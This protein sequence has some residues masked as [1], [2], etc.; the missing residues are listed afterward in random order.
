MSAA[1]AP[2]SLETRM[3]GRGV[4][5]LA[6]KAIENAIKPAH[7]REF[8]DRLFSMPDLAAVTLGN[9]KARLRFKAGAGRAP[10]LLRG[11]AKVMRAGKREQFT[12]ADLELIAVVS[13][14]RPIRIWRTGDRLT[15]LRVKALAPER[16]RFYHPEFRDA[17][18]RAAIIRELTGIA[19]VKSPDGSGWNGG[20][21]E[22]GFHV[23]RMTSG[24]L[25]AIIEEALLATIASA[26]RNSTFEFR[27]RLVDTNLA[28]A[29]VSDFLFPPAR[30]LSIATLW[31]L[32]LRHVRPSM[33]A[34]RNWKVNLHV[35]YS[36]IALL[37]LLSLSF[38][39]SAVMYWMFEFWPRRVKSLR[40]A[41]TARFLA[42]LKRCPRSVWVDRDGTEMEVELG[43]L[44]IG[45]TV[46][47]R[48]GDVAPGDG[49]LISG[50]VLVAESW[51]AGVHRRDVGDVIHCSGQIARGEGR[52]RLDTL[53]AGAVTST[54]ADWHA[55]AMRAPV[56]D[57]KVKRMATAAVL[58][59]LALAALA[60]IRG[61]VSM[62]KG[63][64]RPDYVTG[65]Q[66]ARELG[67]LASVMEAARNGVFIGSDAELEK[68]ARCDCF[69]ISPEIARRHGALPAEEIGEALRGL[70]VEEIL[71]PMGS[72]EGSRSLVLLRKG[73]GESRPVDAGGLIK[74]RQF[75]GKEV[76]FVGDCTVYQEASS[77]ADVSVHVC[78]PPFEAAPPGGI[79]LIEPSLES[80]LA[81]RSI[82]TTYADRQRGGFAT[83][84]VPNVACVIGA[85]YFGVPILGVVALTNAGTLASY[86]Q[87]QRAMRAAGDRLPIT[88]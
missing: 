31:L 63:V 11:I 24:G 53:G 20:Y 50:E 19:Y 15:F 28:L 26:S 75:L 49:V 44:Q 56:S 62:A 43:S 58:P 57:A 68:L 23:G 10:E 81:L 30:F 65:P 18:V 4:L 67:W 51:T 25:L 46:I 55:Q 74:E 37:T 1:A 60:I 54:V 39:G 21:I 17:T 27:K 69:V 86:L 82:A 80:V 22:A 79:V 2:A 36:T 9:G 35:L 42:G 6:G 66:I 12:L 13:Q 52:M 76:A 83:A 61:G 88:G 84:L 38:I 77:Q 72:M 8:I 85:L 33:E 45:D 5:V 78:R 16:Y 40:D 71:T 47:L 73:V 59:A 14:D 48:E 64:I 87:G 29:V 3:A 7:R 34:L 32:N 70:G 41:A